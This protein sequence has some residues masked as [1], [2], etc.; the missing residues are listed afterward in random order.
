MSEE[1]IY[2]GNGTEKFDGDLVEFSVN[3]T[4]VMN[5]G[6]AYIWEYNGDKYIKLKSSK[7]KEPNEYG[8]THSIQINTYN[9]KN[10][11]TVDTE[12]TFASPVTDDDI[13]F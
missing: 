8:K 10:A 12:D 9:P 7:R 4:K 6:K 3:L 1:T 5:E 2:V 11:P 13:P